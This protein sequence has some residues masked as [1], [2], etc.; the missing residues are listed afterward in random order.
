MRG[1]SNEQGKTFTFTPF[2]GLTKHAAELKT[3]VLFIYE[4]GEYAGGNA[5][6]TTE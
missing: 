4:F 3:R 6:W 1:L 5:T 2:T